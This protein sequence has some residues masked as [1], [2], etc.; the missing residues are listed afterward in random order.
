M[1]V[2]AIFCYSFCC[3]FLHVKAPKCDIVEHEKDASTHLTMT[4]QYFVKQHEEH[5]KTADK[6]RVGNIF[7]F[8]SSLDYFLYFY[9][10]LCNQSLQLT[11]VE[12]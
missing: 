9:H 3:E 5:L 12:H 2:T 8:V 10:F 11:F 6:Q 1:S 4:L 7:H